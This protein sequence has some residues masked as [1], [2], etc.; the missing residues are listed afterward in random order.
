L[1]VADTERM[2]RAGARPLSSEQGLALFD[3]CQARPEAVLAPARFDVL[4]LGARPEA[5]HPLLQ[6]LLQ[7][8]RGSR[9]ARAARPLA[10]NAA[11]SSLRERLLALAPEERE[12]H[13]LDFVRTQAATVLGI[14]APGSLEARRPFRELGLDSLMAVELRNRLGAATGLRLP[15]T[16]LFDHPTPMAL[17][18]RL[19][20]L[21]S[22]RPSAP[23]PGL[24]ELEQLDRAFSKLTTDAAREAFDGRL[25]ALFTKWT[26]LHVKAS[27]P[28]DSADDAALFKML[29]DFTARI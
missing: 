11:P 27:A 1:T 22:N 5:A 10:V 2:A 21:L 9:R 17:A 28:V 4:A 19:D 8:S 25:R 26:S 14:A 16:V 15:A 20:S 12:R 7:G 13:L 23:E 3:A 29:D 24:L 18:E 6:H